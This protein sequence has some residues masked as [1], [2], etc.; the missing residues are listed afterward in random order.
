MTACLAFMAGTASAQVIGGKPKVGDSTAGVTSTSGGTAQSALPVTEDAAQ[1][2]DNGQTAKKAANTSTKKSKSAKQT[3]ESA[4]DDESGNA[5]KHS[6]RS[7][8]TK[9][10]NAKEENSEEGA[11][12]Q[13]SQQ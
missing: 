10:K 1:S 12:A 5:K 6:Q 3:K 4:T 9:E 7:S 11:G 2:Q 13:S 8:T